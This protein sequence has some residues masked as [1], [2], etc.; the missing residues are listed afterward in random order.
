[1]HGSLCSTVFVVV[2]I[3]SL[4]YCF[5]HMLVDLV[6]LCMVESIIIL[7]RCRTLFS[8]RTQYHFTNLSEFEQGKQ[9]A[10]WNSIILWTKLLPWPLHG[11]PKI[12][13][14]SYIHIPAHLVDLVGV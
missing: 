7:N 6:D 4:C 13:M 2:S 8:A 10:Q 11:E 12:L 14:L 1:M 9:F 5:V 3:Y